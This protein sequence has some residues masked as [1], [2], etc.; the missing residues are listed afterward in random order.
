MGSNAKPNRSPRPAT[1]GLARAIANFAHSDGDYMTDIPAL[2][3]HRRQ[4]P[5]E[6]L[7][8]IFNLGLGLV[9]QGDKQVMLGEQVISYGPGQ[10][11]LTT[12]DLPVI[13]HVTRASVQE[14]LLG[15]MLKLDRQRIVQTAAE[16]QLPSPS[17]R[18]AY[19]PISIELLDD[20]L[21][22]ALVRLVKLLEEP[23][24]IDRL[25]PLIQQEITIR[26]LT[27]PHGPQLQHLAANG[28]PSQQ[29]AKAVAWLKQNFT[30]SIQVDDLAARAHMSPSTFRQHFRA[31]TGTSPLQYQKQLRLQEARQL[32]LNQNVDA[33]NA[34]GLVGYESASQFSREYSRLF[35]APP[36][37]DV[38][39]MRLMS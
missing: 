8:C 27:G 17:R 2:S 12:I 3:L 1:I 29:I 31:I 36:Q 10:S 35:G 30:R 6:P 23:A 24:L 15:L 32:M 21:L 22:G 5:T 4:G 9:A 11:M 25:A 28:S 37:Q 19:R 39:R 7:H 34:G 13:S 33:G 18:T 16:M 14:P 20:A 26:L 38:R